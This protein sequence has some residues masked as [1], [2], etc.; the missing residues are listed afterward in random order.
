MSRPDVNAG[1][2]RSKFVERSK[3]ASACPRRGSRRRWLSAGGRDAG[4]SHGVRQSVRQDR[5]GDS[6][7]VSAVDI[8][9]RPSRERFSISRVIQA[10]NRSRKWPGLYQGGKRIVSAPVLPGGRLNALD[11]DTRVILWSFSRPTLEAN[12]SFGF[13]T[14]VE[15]GL[16]V[17]SYQALVKL[18]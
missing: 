16:W 14:P 4:S 1:A 2:G 15:G 17:D 18:Q 10:P 9:R 12:W 13:V 6:R 11:L 3:G 5:V 8:R 7:A